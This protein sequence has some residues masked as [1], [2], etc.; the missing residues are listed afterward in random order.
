MSLSGRVLGVAALALL[1]PACGGGGGGGGSGGGPLPPTPGGVTTLAFRVI[2]AEYDRLHDRLVMVSNEPP[3]LHRFDPV[4]G[5]SEEA[6][7]PL[8]PACGSLSPDGLRAAVGHDGWVTIWTLS[9]LELEQA[10]P[11]ST[12][13]LDIVLPGN[14]FAYAFPSLDQWE[15]IRCLELATGE[16]TL[17]T[18]SSLY[19]GARARHR[20]GTDFIYGCENS[21]LSRWS[22]TGGTAAWSA[23]D[24]DSSYLG[25]NLWMSDDGQRLVTQTGLVYS[26][27][28]VQQGSLNM[29]RVQAADFFSTADRLACVG[30]EATGWQGEDTEVRIFRRSDLQPVRRFALPR[31][32]A[33]PGPGL[34]SRGRFLFFNGT[35]TRIYVL[36]EAE[37]NPGLER[38]WGLIPFEADH[39]APVLGV[40][41]QVTVLNSSG[42]ADVRW[43]PMGGADGFKVYRASVPGVTPANYAS[44]PNGAVVSVT[45]PNAYISGL[46]SGVTYYFVV[47]ATAGALEGEPSVEVSRRMQSGLITPIPPQTLTAE[48][49]GSGQVRLTWS[50]S[51][52][53][54]PTSYTVYAGTAPDV[55]RTG[56]V[57]KYE[58]AASPFVA[59]GLENEVPHFFCVTATNAAGESPESLVEARATPAG[60]LPPIAGLSHRVVDAEYSAAL[61]RIVTVGAGPD[62]LYV[63]D[64]ETG[65]ELFVALPAAPQ[66]VSVSP[67]GQK[68][69]VGFNG[70]V[71]W[72]SLA[73]TPAVSGSWTAS[74]DVLDVVEGGNGFIYAFPRTDQWEPIRCIS[75]ATGVENLSSV[76][77]IFAGTL[78]KL[79]PGGSAIYGAQNYISPSDHERY[80]I[81]NG[82]AQYERDSIYHGGFWMGGD[83]WFHEAGHRFY[84]RWTTIFSASA[85]QDEDMRYR[86]SLMNGTLRKVQSVAHS[87][88]AGRIAAIPAVYD[89]GAFVHD[90]TEVRFF[91]DVYADFRSRRALPRFAV[92]PNTYA[93]QGRFVFWRSDGSRCYVLVQADPA[94][95]LALDWGLVTY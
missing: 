79:Q 95:S 21:V 72:V 55:G 88:A 83:L 3:R 63:I 94:A 20:P 58:G 84:T 73:G 68:A 16:E 8:R 25:N 48:P 14:G 54:N 43:S 59:T 26:H 22:T 49:A 37:A 31:F 62:R 39:A 80:D 75:T 27:A 6:T 17:H 57:R 40:P 12:D 82:P 47:T 65:A 4:T 61:D 93:G 56:Y 18:G 24:L 28:L 92:G 36:A 76:Q 53:G 69:A 67:D 29:A 42:S 50:A 89:L 38:T 34:S 23:E 10:W 91:G 2:D 85:V 51:I 45:A 7:L 81:T 5:V 90:D 19:A 35:G 78:A 41:T 33:P 70:S 71:S 77:D 60:A 52:S 30:G 11:V 86:G 46:T 15:R 1:V 66:C 44:L 74:C 13:V 9:P 32:P 87:A 64:P